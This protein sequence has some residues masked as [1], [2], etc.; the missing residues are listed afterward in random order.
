MKPF[1]AMKLAELLE[2]MILIHRLLLGGLDLVYEIE[3]FSATN[4][5]CSWNKST[6]GAR[7]NLLWLGVD[8]CHAILAGRLLPA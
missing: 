3:K 7:S 1:D 4:S 6:L 8:T 2:I 5:T